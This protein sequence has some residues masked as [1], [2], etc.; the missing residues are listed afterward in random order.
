MKNKLW[1]IW[2]PEY[3]FRDST[4]RYLADKHL[5]NSTKCIH[6]VETDDVNNK[7]NICLVKSAILL[8]C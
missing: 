8:S 1:M 5:Y 4:C 7:E 6:K 3:F 2:W